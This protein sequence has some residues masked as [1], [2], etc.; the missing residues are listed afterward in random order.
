MELGIHINPL[1]L[2][3]LFS[4][5]LF[6]T[7]NV[8]AVT[9]K[10][11]NEGVLRE[12]DECTINFINFGVSNDVTNISVKKIYEDLS[13]TYFNLKVTNLINGNPGLRNA[14]NFEMSDVQNYLEVTQDGEKI[15]NY[16]VD[17]GYYSKKY[18]GIIIKNLKTCNGLTIKQKYK[19]NA[20]VATYLL[21]ANEK[22]Q[23]INKSFPAQQFGPS[24]NNVPYATMEWDMNGGL[25]SLREK[26][27]IYID[28]DSFSSSLWTFYIS[29]EN[30][31]KDNCSNTDF[32]KI[33][34]PYFIDYSQMNEFF[35]DFF[36]GYVIN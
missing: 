28:Y 1:N 29:V 31:N 30:I 16:I 35:G 5:L 21:Y 7:F 15:T 10:Y 33:A 6:N 9:V 23:K 19:A 2:L 34:K 14:V 8:N 22:P 17:S 18:I 26:C 25:D 4:I 3:V 12:D 13:N 24:S 20:L 36:E 32:Y 27:G 11:T